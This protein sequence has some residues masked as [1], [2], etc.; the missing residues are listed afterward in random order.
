MGEL[1]ER[2]KMDLAL[3]RFS[4]KTQST[5]LAQVRNISA[6]FNKSP[7]KL[8]RD[9]VRQYLHY[10]IEEKNYSSSHVNQCYSAL[11]FLFEVTLQSEWFLDK[12]PRAK[13]AKKLPAVLDKE[14]VLR[15]FK[16]T[17]NIKHKA[18]LMLIYSAGLRVSE[19]AK[20]KVSD[21]DSKRM[22]I[23]IRSG[24]GGRDRYTTL[25]KTA[26]DMLRRY[27]CEERPEKIP[28]ELLTSE[29]LFTGETPWSPITA[30][31]IQFIFKESLKRAGILKPATVH[32]LRHSFAT[33]LLEAKTDL[34]T[35]QWLMGHKY[36]RTTANY[37]H[38]TQ[39]HL[40]TIKSPLDFP[41]KRKYTKKSV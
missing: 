35:I 14:E 38:V 18:I 32:T 25:S 4:E 37:T 3:R 28:P 2:M 1:R 17:T 8:S 23:F 5:Y 15:L 9:E 29:W 33:H 20:L 7:D 24:K 41:K 19:A 22:M 6:Y 12:I 27:F 10:L 34:P 36:I 26:L 13:K 30:R 16:V 11:K 31:S 39:K 40:S 21:I